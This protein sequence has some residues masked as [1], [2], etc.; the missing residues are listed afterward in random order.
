VGIVDMLMGPIE[1]LQLTAPEM[2]TRIRRRHQAEISEL[3]TLGFDYLSSEG[4]RF[5]LTRM[6]RVFPALVAFGAWTQRTPIWITGGAILLGY[7]ILVYRPKPTYVELDALQ[8]KFVTA[9]EDGVVLVSGNYDYPLPD[10]PGVLRQFKVGTLAET[11]DSHQGRVRALESVGKKVD[12][13]CDY[14]TYHQASA[15]DRTL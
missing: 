6:L 1:Y 7:P 8:A 11:W 2:D 14:Q 15:Q 4:Q 9:F 10:R 13:R 3:M 5:P 12:P